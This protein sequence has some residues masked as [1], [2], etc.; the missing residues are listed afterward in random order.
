MST[1][2]HYSDNRWEQP[3]DRPMDLSGNLAHALPM[4]LQNWRELSDVRERYS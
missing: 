4:N 1:K 3:Q 2:T